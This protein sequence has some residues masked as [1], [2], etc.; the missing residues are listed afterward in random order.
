MLKK[1]LR[2]CPKSN[3]SPNLVTLILSE[4]KLKFSVEMINGVDINLYI[5]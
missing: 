2:S 1:A 3:K 5:L 4:F